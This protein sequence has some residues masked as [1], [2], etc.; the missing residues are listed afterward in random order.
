MIGVVKIRSC[1]AS[2][3]E[4][5]TTHARASVLPEKRDHDL[6]RRLQ[7]N[8]TAAVPGRSPADR[9]SVWDRGVSKR[10]HWRLASKARSSNRAM[11]TIQAGHMGRS[12]ASTMGSADAHRSGSV[13]RSV[14]RELLLGFGPVFGVVC[15]GQTG[16]GGGRICRLRTGV[17]QSE[18]GG[19]S[20]PLAVVRNAPGG[21]GSEGGSRSPH[22]EARPA[23]VL[24][25]FQ[26]PR[27]PYN[28][29]S[30][31]GFGLIAGRRSA[32]RDRGHR[33]RPRRV[34]LRGRGRQAGG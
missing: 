28:P 8:R 33:D 9:P 24:V 13:V 22:P 21:H 29:R 25:H 32:G 20:V 18:K 1:C 30:V 14:G 15:V 31:H 2:A 4:R 3:V 27:R 17:D 5:W 16:S 23:D 12:S 11:H 26:V 7:A 10:D 6:P 34:I 19:P